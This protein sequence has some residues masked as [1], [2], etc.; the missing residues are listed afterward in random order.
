MILC[1]FVR[2]F[3]LPRPG[4]YLAPTESA[5]STFMKVEQEYSRREVICHPVACAFQRVPL[6]PIRYRLDVLQ[7]FFE[8]NLVLIKI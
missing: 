4:V 8:S 5:L 3:R 6:H 2:C 7:T 1:R